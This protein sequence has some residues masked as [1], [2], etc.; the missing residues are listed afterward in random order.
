MAAIGDYQNC[1]YGNGDIQQGHFENVPV[2]KD[3]DDLRQ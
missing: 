3:I 2:H 1:D